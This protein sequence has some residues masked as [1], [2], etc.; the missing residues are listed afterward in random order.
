MLNEVS[1]TQVSVAFGDDART[2]DVTRALLGSGVAWMSGSRWR[3]RT[4][5]RVSVSNWATDAADVAA[6]VEAVRRAASSVAPTS[7]K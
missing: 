7:G 3:G 1:F 4:V 6:S 5:L 2:A